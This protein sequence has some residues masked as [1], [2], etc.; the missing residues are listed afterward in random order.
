MSADDRFELE[1]A[2]TNCWNTVD[3]IDLLVE[4]VIEEGLD[5]DQIAN[6]LIGLRQLHH[7]R[8]KKAFDIFEA[9]IKSG[10]IA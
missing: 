1:Q 2:I 4:N 5:E 8:V 7:M 10:D 6:A 9:L 3:D